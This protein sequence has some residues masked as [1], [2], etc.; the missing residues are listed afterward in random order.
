[1]KEVLI[2]LRG[3]FEYKYNQSKVL[4]NGNMCT[5]VD[6]V[7]YPQPVSV[8]AHTSTSDIDSLEHVECPNG[9][10]DDEE[11]TLVREPTTVLE[12]TE[13]STMVRQQSPAVLTEAQTTDK[14]VFKDSGINS[15][16]RSRFASTLRETS[17]R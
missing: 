2:I 13:T 5:I 1:M 10:E 4:Q 7:K 6:N 3:H 11:D 9:V 12:N 14:A 15:R 17:D 8:V 16:T